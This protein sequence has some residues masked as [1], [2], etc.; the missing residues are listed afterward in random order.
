MI[1]DSFA[2]YLNWNLLVWYQVFHET[3]LNWCGS[4]QNARRCIWRQSKGNWTLKTKLALH[5]LDRHT[6][7]GRNIWDR[8]LGLSQEIFKWCNCFSAAVAAVTERVWFSWSYHML[9]FKALTFDI[10]VLIYL[11]PILIESRDTFQTSCLL[12]FV[13]TFSWWTWK[14]QWGQMLKEMG[15]YLSMEE[16][17]QVDDA[18]YES[19][20]SEGNQYREN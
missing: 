8:S 9:I 19:N 16:P 14:H 11:E 13:W 17:A 4:V 12:L 15:N 10:W 20:E 1:L 3:I 7:K 2:Q 5:L 6:G 18:L